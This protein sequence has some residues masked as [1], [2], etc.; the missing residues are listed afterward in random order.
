M[1]I[2][3]LVRHGQATFQGANPG[4]LTDLG[5]RQA[6]V[7]GDFFAQ[8]GRRFDVCVTGDLSRQTA[9]ADIIGRRV[10]WLADVPRVIVPELNEH[11]TGSIIKALA[12]EMVRP[13][14]SSVDS[15][16]AFKIDRDD[17]RSVFEATLQRWVTGRYEVTDIESWPAFTARVRR[18]LQQTV[19]ALHEKAQALVVSSGGPISATMQWALGLSDESTLRLMWRIRHASVSVFK[20]TADRAELLS[21]NSAAHLELE[22]DRALLTYM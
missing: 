5:R 9:T 6:Q 17:F 7:L 22:N 8:T 11:N 1:S 19:G 16:V 13:N 3:F 15:L 18:G 12:P 20:I 4:E 10:G 14:S 2:V 21:F